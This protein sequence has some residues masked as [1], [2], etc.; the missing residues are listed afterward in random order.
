[1]VYEAMVHLV[2]TV[3]L[4]CTETKT[5]YPIGLNEIL[6][7]PR[8]LGVPSAPSKMISELTVRS[9]QT[10]HLSHIKISTVSKQNKTSFYLSL[11]T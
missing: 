5:L 11:V 10:V 2:H 9:S 3:D 7:D 8:H 4:S 1:M 6:H